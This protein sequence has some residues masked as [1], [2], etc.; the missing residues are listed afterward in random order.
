MPAQSACNQST[1]KPDADLAISADVSLAFVISNGWTVRFL[2]MRIS[3]R[4]VT[5]PATRAP[6]RD[7]CTNVAWIARRAAGHEHSQHV[8]AALARLA[9][10]ENWKA[11]QWP[12]PDDALRI[13]MRGAEKED[14]VLA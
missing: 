9:E 4:F 6:L 10:P 3:S 7:V 5:L 8:L 2:T 1:P 13:V 12:L 11:L 14:R